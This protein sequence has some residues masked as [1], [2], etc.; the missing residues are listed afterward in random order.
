MRGRRVLR[1]LDGVRVSECG[2]DKGRGGGCGN[3]G[4]SGARLRLG[5]LSLER[6]VDGASGRR[7]RGRSC[8]CAVGGGCGGGGHG[9]ISRACHGPVV[10]VVV[11]VVVE[12]VMDLSQRRD[13]SVDDKPRSAASSS[14]IARAGGEREDIA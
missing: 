5:L 2:R 1:D 8:V 4:F 14:V 13:N 10:V 6:G 7:S 3:G 9:F 11:V 12:T